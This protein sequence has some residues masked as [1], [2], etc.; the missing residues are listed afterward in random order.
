MT[1]TIAIPVLVLMAAVT[2]AAMLWAVMTQRAMVKLRSRHAAAEALLRLAEQERDRDDKAVALWAHTTANR[3]AK[4]E[5]TCKPQP[6]DMHGRFIA[7]RK[8]VANVLE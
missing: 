7:A 5:A 3:I 8:G 1:A 2:G 4:L 6:R